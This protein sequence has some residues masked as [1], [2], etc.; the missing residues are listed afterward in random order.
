MKM[1]K[2]AAVLVLSGILAVSSA[3]PSLA[4]YQNVDSIKGL[5][6]NGIGSYRTCQDLGV[7]QAI[8][9]VRVNDIASGQVGGEDRML[10]ENKEHGISNTVIIQNQ[11]QTDY[12]ELLPVSEPAAGAVLYAFNVSTEE[13]RAAVRRIAKTWANRYADIASNWV[14]GNE[15]NDG[16]AWNYS[17][18]QDLTAYTTDYATAFRIWYEEIKA[19]NPDARVFIPFDHRFNWPGG[20]GAGYYQAKDM[21]PILNSQLSDTDYGIAWHAYPEGLSDPIFADDP[22][23]TD[24]PNAPIINMKNLH[25]LTNFMQQAEYLSPAGTVRHLILSEQGFNS[26]FGEELQAQA[27]AA[28]YEAAKANPYVEGFFLNREIDLPGGEMGF[29][30][31]LIGPDGVTRKQAYETYKNLQ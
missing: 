26:S 19:A 30:F 7:K 6:V 31:G 29:N 2:K 25:V 23:A 20:N 13:S 8:W 11:W 21:L 3:M 18:Q 22:S 17:P 28:A 14:I 12:P 10:R 15:I 16:N 4:F 27:L 5:H 1:Q 9:N 24:S